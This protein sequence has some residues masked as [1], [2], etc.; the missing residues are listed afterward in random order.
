MNRILV[1][2]FIFDYYFPYNIRVFDFLFL[3]FC[4]LINSVIWESSVRLFETSRFSQLPWRKRE[5]KI[6]ASVY[7]H[8]VCIRNFN[9]QKEDENTL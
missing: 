1:N 3:K 9:V 2:I 8:K 6:S 5:K 4:N 7:V